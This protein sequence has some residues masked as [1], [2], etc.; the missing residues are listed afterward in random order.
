MIIKTNRELLEHYDKLGPGDLFIGH[1]SAGPLTENLMVDLLERGVRCLPSLLSQVLTRSKAA[2]A[3]V[4]KTWMLPHT[5]VISRRSDIL[6]AISY[7]GKYSIGPVVTK[8]DRLNCGHGIRKWEDAEAMYNLLAFQDD[9]VS[10]PF[11]M[12]PYIE[13]FTDVRVILAGDYVEAY[14]RENRTSFRKNLSSGGY[15]RP[16]VLN[17]FQKKLCTEIMR[18]GQF[19]Y[20]HIDLHILD[21]GTVYLSE[22]ALGGGTKGAV[23]TNRELNTMKKKLLDQM[24]SFFSRNP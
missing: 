5:R 24:A 6:N 21:D 7:Y 9:T 11:V 15:S 1:L 4:F 17:N 3:A 8:E 16:F 22:I 2:Q 12:Q 10:Y 23:V 14:T 18:R 13:N 20:A 19:P